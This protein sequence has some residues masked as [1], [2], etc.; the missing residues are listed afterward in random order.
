MVHPG[1]E[2][3]ADMKV[4]YILTTFPS[5]SE[6][7]ARREVLALKALGWDVSVFAANAEIGLAQE[8][9]DELVFYRPPAW[10]WRA[11]SAQAYVLRRHRA[12]VLRVLRLVWKM[13]REHPPDGLAVLRNLHTVACF[14]RRL[15]ELGIRHIHAYFL[16][17]PAC[18]ACAMAV[19]SRRSMSVS[20]HARDI[21]VEAGAVRV[22]AEHARFIAACTEQG[23]DHLRGLLPESHRR[24]VHL[25]YHGVESG[26][27][28]S[29]STSPRRQLP[30]GA[31]ES[32]ER[33]VLA[34]GRFVAKKGFDHLV[35]AFA[36]MGPSLHPARL[37]LVGD[38]PQRA[39]LER[40]A[41]T[42]ALGGRVVFTGWQS[43]RVVRERMES[44][45]LLAV[46]SVIAED[47]DRDG[48]P[49][50]VLEAMAA[51]LPVVGSSLP[52]IREAITHNETG[53]LVAPGNVDELAQAVE[54][55]LRNDALRDRL[56]GQAIA[57]AR[58]RFDP[59][60]N[61]RKIAELLRLNTAWGA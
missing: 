36:R 26:P 41:A 59:Q 15:D 14:T 55:L 58:A 39:G 40:L 16:S 22:K 42:L 29:M 34:V 60:A 49:N 2:T 27:A 54:N 31:P 50:V 57:V 7:F 11:M 23:A 35:R 30:S 17:W 37:V 48:I 6:A 61:A 10:S 13:F 32:P 47:S 51:G 53:I 56:A 18:V 12:G 44:A 3:V 9:Q 43:G 45:A 24:K 19:L 20:A 8:A 4:A 5:G 33:V 28:R 21:F 1:A 46:P 38:G 52:G 25:V